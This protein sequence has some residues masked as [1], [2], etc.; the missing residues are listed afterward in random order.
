ME[1]TTFLT[2]TAGSSKSRSDFFRGSRCPLSLLDD[3]PALTSKEP[4]IKTRESLLSAGLGELT[5]EVL[6]QGVDVVI[7]RRS[8]SSELRCSRGW[9]VMNPSTRPSNDESV[10]DSS[11]D[12]SYS[13]SL[14]S[15]KVIRSDYRSHIK[16][17]ACDTNLCLTQLASSYSH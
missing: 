2:L 16:L 14:Q 12:K 13:G 9:M 3:W 10:S 17:A 1:L 5:F 4:A 8:S 7:E 6:R 15:S 11:S